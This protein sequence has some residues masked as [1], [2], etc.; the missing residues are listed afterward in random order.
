VRTAVFVAGASAVWGLLPIIAFNHLHLGSAGYGG[1][2]G[3][4]GLGALVG[5]AGLPRLRRRLSLDGVV[6]ASSLVFGATSLA[7]ALTASLPVIAVALFAGG[8]AWVSAFASLNATAYA[9]MPAW[10]RSRALAAYVLVFY[11]GQAV[12]TAGWGVV[13]QRTTTSAALVAA[14][15]TLFVGFGARRRFLLSEPDDVDPR[16]SRHWPEP[17]VVLQP[18]DYPGHVMVVVDHRVPP[19][20]AVAFV[21]AMQRVGR[22]RRRTGARQWALY[23]DASD[24]ERFVETY[25]VDSWDDH[26]RQ[27]HERT[28]ESDRS[29]EDAASALTVDGRKRHTQ[30]LLPMA[31]S[32]RD[33]R[34]GRRDGH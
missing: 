28:T 26:L 18:G 22:A 16:P 33:R 15:L 6:T 14:G 27:H 11:G 17:E 25:V 3:C 13:A 9:I 20:N 12:A 29:D 32:G 34:R 8:I 24:P 10:V 30:H 2:L 21:G 7:L 31:P 1:L 4:L 19:D 5:S 23:R